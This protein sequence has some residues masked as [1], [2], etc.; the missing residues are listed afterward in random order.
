MD[1]AGQNYTKHA[2]KAGERKERRAAQKKGDSRADCIHH[3]ELKESEI[4]N[5]HTPRSIPE[6]SL[7]AELNAQNPQERS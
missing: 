6:K 1:H 3:Q 2:T 7:P 4:A 5:V